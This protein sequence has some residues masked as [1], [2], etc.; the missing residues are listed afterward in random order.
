MSA[1]AGDLPPIDPE[2]NEL[3]RPEKKNNG[4]AL[5]PDNTMFAVWSGARRIDPAD[6][7]DSQIMR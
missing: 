3:R 7:N 1:K 2:C 6:A 4:T 5:A